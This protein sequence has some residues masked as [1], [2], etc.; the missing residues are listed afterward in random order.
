MMSNDAR[1]FPTSSTAAGDPPPPA[2]EFTCPACRS[3]LRKTDP[4]HV[5]DDTCRFKNVESITWS[6]P[7]CLAR[8]NRAHESHTNDHTCQWAIARSMPEGASRERGSTHTRGGCIPASSD[9][10]AR[11]RGDGRRDG[12]PGNESPALADAAAPAASSEA[13]E[14]LSPE[15]AEERR[16]EKAQPVRTEQK[17]RRM[18]FQH[19]LNMILGLH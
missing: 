16:R 18:A 2:T 7:G 1:Y 14:I 3:H 4:K 6:C 19:G 12:A 13:P 5:R 11:M 8:R 17:L 15:E 10:T 9:P